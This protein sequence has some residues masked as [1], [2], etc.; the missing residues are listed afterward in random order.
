MFSRKKEEKISLSKSILLT[1]PINQ[2]KRFEKMLLKKGVKNSI[3]IA[4][5]VNINL[6][7]I[8]GK[9]YKEIKAFIVSSTNAIEAIKSNIKILSH[10]SENKI[11]IYCVGK[12][13]AA[14]GK[15]I[16][17]ETVFYGLKANELIERIRN[18]LVNGTFHALPREICY[19]RGK[20]ITIDISSS[21][22]ICEK[23]V[24]C[25]CPNDLNPD[26]ILKL[27]NGDV[28]YVFFFSK[29]TVDLFFKKINAIDSEIKIF[30]FS[31][32]IRN[33]VT[34][35][36]GTKKSKLYF[37]KRPVASDLVSLFLSKK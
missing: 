20:N 23:V 28:G 6:K 3:I 27:I 29:N 33:R 26:I 17:L 35:L 5:M 21:L 15:A 30:C 7:K 34:E 11:P 8:L 12:H 13:T 24:Y 37:C 9:D 31:E 16:G 32:S 4:P 19:L 25:Q 2:S 22:G 18:K 10:L 14:V 1:R 36:L